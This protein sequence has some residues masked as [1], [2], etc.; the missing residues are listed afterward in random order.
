[1]SSTVK[2]EG[3]WLFWLAM[4]SWLPLLA[5]LVLA[6]APEDME[7][8]AH[9]AVTYAAAMLSFL[10]GVRFGAALLTGK[11]SPLHVRLTPLVALTGM[12]ALILPTQVALAILVAGYAGLGALDAFAGMQG[13]VPQSYVSARMLMTWLFALTLLGI[14]LLMGRS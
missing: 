14:L 1:M 11:E 10:G 7:G 4:A 6:I 3:R 8:V 9:L 2:G 13:R 5:A 12:L